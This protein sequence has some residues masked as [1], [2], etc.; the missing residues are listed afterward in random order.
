MDIMDVVASVEAKICTAEKVKAMASADLIMHLTSLGMDIGTLRAMIKNESDGTLREWEDEE[1]EEAKRFITAM[2]KSVE[3]YSY[4]AEELNR[5]I[6]GGD[7]G[8]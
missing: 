8:K 4:M 3:S 7:D 2:N 6:P 1:P 5:R